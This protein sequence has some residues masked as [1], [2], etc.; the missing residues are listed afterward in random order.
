MVIK[1]WG[2]GSTKG[3]GS[4]CPLTDIARLNPTLIVLAAGDNA[5]SL[6][7]RETLSRVVP[8]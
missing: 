5:H 8:I 4:Q 7:V 1:T 2:I 6:G 3:H